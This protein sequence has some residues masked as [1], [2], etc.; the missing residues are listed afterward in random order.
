MSANNIV[1]DMIARMGAFCAAPKWV[2]GEIISPHHQAP[3]I[4]IKVLLEHLK[5]N[6]PEGLDIWY[7]GFCHLFPVQYNGKGIAPLCHE[8][9]TVGDLIKQMNDLVSTNREKPKLHVIHGGKKNV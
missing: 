5:E 8:W 1:S 4:P 6:A 7:D 3:S 2:K 9:R